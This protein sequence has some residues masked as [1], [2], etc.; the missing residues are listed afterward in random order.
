MRVDEIE[1]ADRHVRLPA[2][3]VPSVHPRLQVLGNTL[4]GTRRGGMKVSSFRFVMN[5][6]V[7][8]SLHWVPYSLTLCHGPG[9]DPALWRF[10]CIADGHVVF[11]LPLTASVAGRCAC[12]LWMTCGMVDFHISTSASLD[13][14]IDGHP[15]ARVP[16]ASVLEATNGSSFLPFSCI[17]Q[18]EYALLDDFAA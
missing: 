5:G 2:F 16:L 6:F 3:A 13:G 12:W 15:A 18:S 7:L 17:A 14:Y 9:P 4:Q 10:T 1:A 8:A 11:L